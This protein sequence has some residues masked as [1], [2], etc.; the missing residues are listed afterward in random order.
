LPLRDFFLLTF[1]LSV[2]QVHP[3]P[4]HQKFGTYKR[5]TQGTVN[6]APKP[7]TQKFPLSAVYTPAFSIH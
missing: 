6:A 1:Y 5:A 4:A 3:S 2:H 7:G